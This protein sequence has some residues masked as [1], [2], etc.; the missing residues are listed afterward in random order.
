[1]RS[2]SPEDKLADNREVVL[3]IRFVLDRHAELKYGELLD[4]HAIRQGRFVSLAELT[5][6]VKKWLERQSS[7]SVSPGDEAG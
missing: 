7:D 1:V 4:G 2:L 6:G 5:G 3:V